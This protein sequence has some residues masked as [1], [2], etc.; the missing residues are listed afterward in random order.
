M[1]NSSG[2]TSFQ[3]QVRANLNKMIGLCYTFIHYIFFFYIIC[4]SVKMIN[5]KKSYVDKG[6]KISLQ[7]LWVYH[8]K[9]VS[10]K[11]N[12]YHFVYNYKLVSSET[13][14]IMRVDVLT[15]ENLKFGIK[16]RLK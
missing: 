14:A 6:K 1:T 3:F 7:S 5:K 8:G 2:F 10:I 11:R 13:S 9:V 12:N 15:C 16:E 4:T